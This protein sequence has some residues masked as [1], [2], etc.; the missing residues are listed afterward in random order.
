MNISFGVLFWFAF[1]SVL[2]ALAGEKWSDDFGSAELDTTLWCPC[3]INLSEAPIEFLDDPDQSGDRI[4]RIAVDL[5]SLG[6]NVCRTDDPDYEC[7]KPITM[8]SLIPGQSAFTEEPD[9]PEFLGPSFLGEQKLVPFMALTESHG[10]PYCTDD[11][12]QQALAAGEENECYQRQEI[13]FQSPYARPSDK[14][15]IY[16]FRFRMPA[17]IFDEKNSIRW[18]T[19]QWKQEPISPDYKT[20]P[21]E[22]KWDPSPV[23]AQRFDDGV[24]HITVQDENCRCRI[25]SALLPDGSKWPSEPGPATDCKST[26][27]S[28]AGAQCSAD[29]QLEYGNDPVLPSPKG[30]WVEM[31]YQVQMSRDKPATLE[32]FADGRFIVR[33]A[34]KIGYKPMPGKVSRTKFKMGQY[35]DYIPSIDAMDID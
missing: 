14:P 21:G 1:L 15:Y 35:R 18:V 12:W 34:G 8:F 20:Q 9:T 6:G 28:D 30:N 10:S 11:I 23:V 17:T 32:V 19:A 31:Q 2:P 5:N 4:A 7:G 3:Q 33:V 27:L 29:L 25:A 26:R 13:K 16:K 24:L 22:E